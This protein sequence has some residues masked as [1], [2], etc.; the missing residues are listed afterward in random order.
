MAETIDA[1]RIADGTWEQRLDHIVGVLRRIS[2]HTDSE[3]M[4]DA[5]SSRMREFRRG[6]AVHFDSD[7]VAAT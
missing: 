4:V 1:I 2:Q 5:C 6:A 7:T 3:Q